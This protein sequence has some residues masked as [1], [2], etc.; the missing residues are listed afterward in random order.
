MLRPSER[1]EPRLQC[2]HCSTRTSMSVMHG[3]FYCEHCDRLGDMKCH[4]RTIFANPD[5]TAPEPRASHPL[6]SSVAK[7][8][9][10]VAALHSAD[11]TES[12]VSIGHGATARQ[13][14]SIRYLLR[15]RA[16]PRDTCDAVRTIL[17]AIDAID[18][19][20]LIRALDVFPK[21]WQQ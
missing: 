14:G 10:I 2:S 20:I 16:V 11:H 21:R 15:D 8:Q 5:N 13:I 19:E 3:T 4:S 9:S 6:T 7:V 17:S 18:A 12:T 1:E